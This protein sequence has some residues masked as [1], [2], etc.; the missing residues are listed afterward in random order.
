MCRPRLAWSV[1][2]LVRERRHHRLGNGQR[3]REAHG[4]TGNQLLLLFDESCHR[5]VSGHLTFE[6]LLMQSRGVLL[7]LL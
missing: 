7:S 5:F 6:V 3:C 4:L 2:K 1:L